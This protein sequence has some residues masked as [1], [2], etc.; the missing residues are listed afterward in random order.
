[1]HYPTI[2]HERGRYVAAGIQPL[3]HA[4]HAAGVTIM[5][6]ID[7]PGPMDEIPMGV[8]LHDEIE[9][10]GQSGMRATSSPSSSTGRSSRSQQDPVQVVGDPGDRPHGPPVPCPPRPWCAGSRPD[11]REAA[12]ALAS[13]PPW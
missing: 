12:G 3:L 4:L 6:G 5:D 8:S 13:G 2:R 10:F 11:G 9:Q 7:A 1:M